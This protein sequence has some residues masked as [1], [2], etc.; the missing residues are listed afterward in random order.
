MRSKKLRLQKKKISSLTKT[1]EGTRKRACRSQRTTSLTHAAMASRKSPL[2]KINKL[3]EQ[4]ES[5]QYQFHGIER[6]GD[7]A[8]ASEIKYG[9]ISKT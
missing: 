2:E 4:I 6:E 8:K 7:F 5:A 3:K 1:Y 9:T